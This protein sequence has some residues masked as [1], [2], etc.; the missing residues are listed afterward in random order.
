MRL[1]ETTRTVLADSRT[2]STSRETRR[3]GD[4]LARN[5]ADSS[6][7]TSRRAHAGPGSTSPICASAGLV[8]DAAGRAVSRLSRRAVRCRYLPSPAWYISPEGP[9]CS[10]RPCGDD[11]RALRRPRPGD[12]RAT[13][14]LGA[15]DTRRRLPAAATTCRGYRLTPFPHP[16]ETRTARRLA[17]EAGRR[18]RYPTSPRGMNGQPLLV[19]EACG[20]VLGVR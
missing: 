12:H 6:G 20:E 19:R 15:G 8:E 5:T 2:S 10:S 9:L 13:A 17:R 3:V 18:L 16:S 4:E 14:T 11:R 7:C 1:A